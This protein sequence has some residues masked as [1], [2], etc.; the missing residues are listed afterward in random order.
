MP[1]IKG[2]FTVETFD[3]RMGWYPILV[4]SESNIV[5][6]SESEAFL[7][8]EETEQTFTALGESVPTLRVKA[9][10]IN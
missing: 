9:K 1:Q 5:Y 7:K 2:L 6:F 3:S 10:S 4:D 8:L